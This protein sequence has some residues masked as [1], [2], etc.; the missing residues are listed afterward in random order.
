[1]HMSEG[2]LLAYLDGELQDGRRDEVA[3]HL[4]SC[5]DCRA[6]FEELRSAS[7]EFSS[8]L[9]VL[10]SA[11]PPLD[12]VTVARLA[13]MRRATAWRGSPVGV[14]TRRAPGALLRAAVVVLLL[15]GAALAAIPGSPVR[16]WVSRGRLSVPPEDHPVTPEVAAAE[17]ESSGEEQAPPVIG[18]SVLPVG[19]EAMVVVREATGAT[20]LRVRLVDSAQLSVQWEGELPDPHFRTAPGRIEVVAAGA[21]KLLVELPRATRA[22]VVVGDRTYAVVEGGELRPLVGADQASEDEVVFT[23]L[24]ERG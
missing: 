20:R 8:A 2:D 21:G 3:L 9:A 18:V 15:G 24:N 23:G 7:E 5:V 14:V 19:G 13:Q 4:A 16:D 12:D 11:A 10:D 22:T 17:A 1:M 6:E